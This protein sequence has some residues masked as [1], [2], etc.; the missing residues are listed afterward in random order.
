MKRKGH[1]SQ[2]NELYFGAS[3]LNSLKG[4]SILVANKNKDRIPDKE[5][6]KR[7]SD[8]KIRNECTLKF[9]TID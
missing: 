9:S 2:I 5:S 4:S 7:K 6:P 8:Y 3:A 1:F